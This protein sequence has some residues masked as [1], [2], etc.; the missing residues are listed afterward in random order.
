MIQIFNAFPMLFSWKD[1]MIKNKRIGDY[2]H[3]RLFLYFWSTS[4]IHSFEQNI[5]PVGLYSSQ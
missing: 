2:A 5:E 3:P 1:I 4:S